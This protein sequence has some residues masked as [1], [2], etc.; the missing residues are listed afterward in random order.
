[1]A[2]TFFVLRIIVVGQH[3]QD[4]LEILFAAAL[5]LQSA[6]LRTLNPSVDP[7]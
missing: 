4:I 3:A 6:E 2:Y 5:C 7:S 1:M